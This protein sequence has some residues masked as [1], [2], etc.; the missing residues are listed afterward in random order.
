MS[1]KTLYL[2]SSWMNE[3][4]K[5]IKTEFESIDSGWFNTNDSSMLADSFGFIINLFFMC[6]FKLEKT[7]LLQNHFMKWE[8]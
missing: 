8:N 4:I 2:K 5:I 6:F 3:L 1:E 7:M